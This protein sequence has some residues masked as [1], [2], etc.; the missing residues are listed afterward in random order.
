MSL[1][2]T[3]V[4]ATGIGMIPLGIVL[5]GDPVAQGGAA[6]L[7]CIL[8]VVLAR[9]GYRQVQR[10]SQYMSLS[11]AARRATILEQIAAELD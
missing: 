8:I 5:I 7:Y 10:Q 2:C 4:V 1:Q 11:T 6:F 3:T 9:T